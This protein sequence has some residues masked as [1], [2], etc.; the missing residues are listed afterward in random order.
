MIYRLMLFDDEIWVIRGLLKAIPWE[1]LGFK[2]IYHSTNSLE[3][4]DKIV[5]M[6]PH[7]V[8]SDIKMPG[9]T[10]LELLE[11]T[12]LLDN[13][14]RFVL[15]SAYAEFE[16]AHKA[17]RYG[18]FDYLIKP[19][20][21]EDVVRTLQSVRQVLDQESKQAGYQ[22]EEQ[23]FLK[24]EKMTAVQLFEANDRVPQ[25][26]KGL[27]IAC[28]KGFFDA[29]RVIYHRTKEALEHAVL[30]ENDH[31]C[32]ALVDFR[33]HTG[34]LE[35]QLKEIADSEMAYMG[36]SM[37]FSMD[38][39]VNLYVE[40]AAYAALQ[41]MV[42]SDRN[43]CA[44]LENRDKEQTQQWKQSLAEAF[45]QGNGNLLA[46]L[47]RKLP[48]NLERE[49]KS[50]YDFVEVANFIARELEAFSIKTARRFR[51][52]SIEAFLNNYHH[53]SEYFIDLQ[54]EISELFEEKGQSVIDLPII[55]KYIEQNYTQ[56]Q[57]VG[58]IAERF[59]VDLAYL[60]RVF[61]Q[62]KGEN[63]KAYLTAK[64]MDRAK[65]LLLY[66]DLKIY[67]VTEAVGYSDYFYFTKVFRK[68]TGQTP[69]QFREQQ[70]G[71]E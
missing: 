68:A 22:V 42:C 71:Q 55:E 28:A 45:E 46:G 70:G 21:K 69:S 18:A 15:I 58:D 7:L 41:F 43:V 64:K 37:P 57:S 51:I 16:Y 31:F 6:Q 11:K 50:F 34:K 20:K 67:E 19:L 5:Q 30:F 8:L 63:M 35:E 47:L 39:F 2:V 36:L 33:E 52:D 66:T 29:D 3:A 59:H 4:Y 10:G 53:A 26:D 38:G 48:D 62:T 1:E 14:P 61:K 44:F 40:Q 24:R 23:L 9:I 49:Q 17:L 25:G 27:V 32:F 12:Q 60:S 54:K 56:I 65:Y 13:P